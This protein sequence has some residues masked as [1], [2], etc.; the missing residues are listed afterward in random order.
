MEIQISKI[1]KL[2]F[3]VCSVFLL[4][5]CAFLQPDPSSDFQ[6]KRS[7]EFKVSVS[8]DGE[9]VSNFRTPLVHRVSVSPRELRAYL[10]ED[11]QALVLP[12][13]ARR[14]RDLKGGVKGIRVVKILSGKR[15][16][17]GLIQNDL[18]TAV[19]RQHLSGLQ[20]LGTLFTVLRTEK[21]A[22]LTLER[23]G[24]PHKILYYL[25]SAS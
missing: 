8:T 17:L 3:C 12:F 10:S 16:A 1:Y 11:R 20:D 24:K 4:S 13:Q 15:S 2:V 23:E 5:S 7:G 19:G 25:D 21:Q 18:L 9:Q 14:V 22:S 6:Q